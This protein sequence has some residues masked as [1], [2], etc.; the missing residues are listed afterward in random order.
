MPSP[1]PDDRPGSF[2]GGLD[3]AV[4]VAYAARWAGAGISSAHREVEQFHW[5][6][7]FA[8]RGHGAG[9]YPEK[10]RDAFSRLRGRHKIGGHRRRAANFS[11]SVLS[12][13]SG[14]VPQRLIGAEFTQQRNRA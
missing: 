2:E 9:E 4:P 8:V 11:D 13:V 12:V 10:L 6:A 1:P 3:P 7:G 5:V 14:F